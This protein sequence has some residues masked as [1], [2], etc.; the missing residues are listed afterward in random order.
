MDPF[1]SP[2]R[3][4]NNGLHNPFPHSLLSTRQLEE[5]G[6]LSLWS[7]L[8][9]LGICDRGFKAHALDLA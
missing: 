3:I 7:R 6:D 5:A 8:V 4:P 2:Y 1:S 9:R